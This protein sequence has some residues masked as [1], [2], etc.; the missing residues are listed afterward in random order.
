MT[1]PT[2]SRQTESWFLLLPPGWA[3]FPVAAGQERELDAAIE[4]VVAGSVPPDAPRDSAEPF[5]RMLRDELRNTLGA[6]RD[7]GA[8]AVYLP[9][10][11]VGGIA[12]PASITEMEASAVVGDDPSAVVAGILEGGYE[13]STVVEVDGRPAARVV[14]TLR[15]VRADDDAPPL[16]SRQV[17]Y[18]IS[19]DESAGDWL[20]LSFSTSWAASAGE[21]LPDALVLFFDALVSTLRWAGPGTEFADLVPAAT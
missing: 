13:E 10:A 16:S 17:L 1:Q 14:Q 8:G 21:D 2:A 20:V 7:A 12:I 5:R 19:R 11:L 4:R 18:V 9:T 3:R 6:A 15:D